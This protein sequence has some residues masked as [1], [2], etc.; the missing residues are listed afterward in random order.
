MANNAQ[1]YMLPAD[2]CREIF[3]TATEDG[4]SVGMCVDEAQVNRMYL[5]IRRGGRA[6]EVLTHT[7]GRMA[8]I[9]DF[10]HITAM[11]YLNE[12]S[13]IKPFLYFRVVCPLDDNFDVLELNKLLEFELPGADSSAHLIQLLDN[14]LRPA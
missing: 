6:A 8:V 7:L 12:H 2:H 4:P 5:D 13:A 3:F 14:P 1:E 9:P 11:A 10:D